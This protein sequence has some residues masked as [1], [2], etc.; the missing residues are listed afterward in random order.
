MNKRGD[1]YM[2]LLKIKI[3]V[4]NILLKYRLTQKLYSLYK[5]NKFNREQ[6]RR[7]RL[8]S[9][10]K[11]CCL[12]NS[13]KGKRCF[14]IGNGPSLTIS[15]LN[16]LKN[17]DTFAV[18]RIYKIF[19]Q[20]D[21]RP[22]YY[23]SQDTRVL[24]E[25][26]NDLQPL[27]DICQGVFLNSSIRLDNPELEKKNLYY[28]FLNLQHYES[29]LPNFSDDASKGIYEGFTVAYACIQLAVYMGY[30]EIY[31]LGIDHNYTFTPG[32]NGSAKQTNPSDNYMKGLEGE[33]VYAPQTDKSTLAYRKARRVCD[34]KNIIIKN[35]TRGGK[36][37]E[38]ER[39]DFD[40]L[41]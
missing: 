25:V 5:K 6:K 37:E 7:Y 20:T 39:I 15:D 26:Y 28:I 17:E 1:R 27:Y 16:K 4:V 8:S 19:N 33:L 41:F 36:L 35:A 31:L 24:E 29:E 12:K 30:S 32:E 9:R 40:K 10:K 11:I 21:W 13:K 18:N 38:F 34:E 23:C 14:V 3:K 2:L 22:T